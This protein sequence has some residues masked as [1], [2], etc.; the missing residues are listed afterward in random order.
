MNFIGTVLMKRST[1]NSVIV[2]SPNE[3][4]VIKV[5]KERSHSKDKRKQ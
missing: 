1:E 5:G 4:E 3:D 2:P